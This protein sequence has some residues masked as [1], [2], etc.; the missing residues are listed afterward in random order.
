MKAFDLE[1]RRLSSEEKARVRH[2]IL[3]R[4]RHV[5]ALT[6]KADDQDSKV[7]WLCEN[8]VEMCTCTHYDRLNF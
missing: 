2:E 7:C 3:W 6:V 4:T 1:R 5:Q 8:L